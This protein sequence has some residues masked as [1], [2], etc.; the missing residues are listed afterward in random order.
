MFC[1]KCGLC[2]KNLNLNPI[3]DSLHYGDGVCRYLDLNSNLC[4]IYKKRPIFCNIEKSYYLFFD[5]IYTTEE[6]Y[7][8]N[9]EMCLKLKNWES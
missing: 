1:D 6:F 9:Y 2:C 5:K 8:L 4:K 7:K 3:Y